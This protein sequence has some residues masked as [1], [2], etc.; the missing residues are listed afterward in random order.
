[1]KNY[2]YKRAWKYY[3]SVT[4]KNLRH[5]GIDIIE[6]MSWGTHFCQF[7]Q[8]KEDLIDILVP[9]FKAGLENNEFCMWITSQPLEIEAAKE[10]LGKAVPDINVYLD[11]GQ[12]EI[13]SYFHWYVNDGAFDSNRVLNGWVEKLNKAL[14]NGYDGLR[15]TGNTF[16]LAKE[17]WEDFVD[18]EKDI[19][20]VLGNYQMIALCTYNFDRCNSTETIDVVSNHKFALIKKKGEWEQIES[21]KLKRAEK[22]EEVLKII[23]SL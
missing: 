12:L 13:I 1:M 7:Y 23:Q 9:Y 22:V 4:N 5:S 19:D 3:L 11:Q 14:A 17:D 2:N 20:R 15:L 16:W 6:N 10:A 8:T 18:Y 21:S